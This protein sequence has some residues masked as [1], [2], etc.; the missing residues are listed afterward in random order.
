MFVWA[1]SWNTKQLESAVVKTYMYTFRAAVFV[2]KRNIIKIVPFFL[3]VLYFWKDTTRRSH[4]YRHSHKVRGLEGG[5]CFYSHPH[6][7][8]KYKIHKVI[9]KSYIAG[10]IAFIFWTDSGCRARQKR[11]GWRILLKLLLPLFIK[12]Y[13]LLTDVNYIVTVPNTERIRKYAFFSIKSMAC[14][15]LLC[16]EPPHSW[17]HSPN[18][19]QSE[20]LRFCS[21]SPVDMVS[22]DDFRLKTPSQR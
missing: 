5:G 20:Y 2:W 8:V 1:S 21:T 19:P 10:S 11:N 4:I 9:H 6:A 12:Y 16:S 22:I 18:T 15:H 17:K 14:S 7:S 13:I 3:L